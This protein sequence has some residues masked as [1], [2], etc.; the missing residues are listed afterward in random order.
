MVNFAPQLSE[1]RAKHVRSIDAA[2]HTVG[3]GRLREFGLDDGATMRFLAAARF[4]PRE[5]A[6]LL[7][8]ALSWHE[9]HHATLSAAH[10]LHAEASAAL[11]LNLLPAVTRRGE[12]VMVVSPF[13]QDSIKW[14][15]HSEVWHEQAGVAICALLARLAD[16]LSRRSDGLV[17]IAIVID[18]HGLPAPLA[19]EAGRLLQLHGRLFRDAEHMYPAVVARVLFARTPPFAA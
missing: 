18:L 2:T 13:A 7:G 17:R 15:S 9:T 11:A 4:D 3:A 1:L 19:D 5:G 10:A 8:R 16:S 12:R 14:R 6:E